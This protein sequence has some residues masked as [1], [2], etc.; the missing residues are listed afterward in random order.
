MKQLGILIGAVAL[1]LAIWW[2]TARDPER[3]RPRLVRPAEEE[4]NDPM[5]WTRAAHQLWRVAPGHFR[6]EEVVDFIREVHGALDDAQFLAVSAALLHAWLELGK[7]EAAQPH[8][9]AL[10][11]AIVPRILRIG[12]YREIENV[13][14]RASSGQQD[15]EA[16]AK[17]VD[18]V[19]T[20]LVKEPDRLVHGAVA[21]LRVGDRERFAR[22]LDAAGA[23][24]LVAP[25]NKAGDLTA[26][27]S[28]GSKDVAAAIE[29]W[30]DAA[31][32]EPMR[33]GLR[34]LLEQQALRTLRPGKDIPPKASVAALLSETAKIPGASEY[35]PRVARRTMEWMWMA[36]Y[37]EM[38]LHEELLRGVETTFGLMGFQTQL[39]EMAAERVV[40]VRPEDFSWPITFQERALL[41]AP[42]EAT[43]LRLAPD[44][45]KGLAR[46][47]EFD[48][49]RAALRAALAKANTER[50]RKKIE[51]LTEAL[52]HEEA[53]MLAKAERER[54]RVESERLQGQLKYMR[55]E[56]ERARKQGR[57]AEDISSIERVVRALER[58]STE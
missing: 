56:L 2:I 20:E 6:A 17:E 29:V 58:Q 22:L 36:H 7:D 9:A 50:G 24:E 42:D 37:A 25:L 41:S 39:W 18:A 53:K 10:A 38:K 33:H 28:Q 44:V 13:L 30:S 11:K 34:P 47:G 21:A 5:V 46:M 49:G 31:D 8:L 54:T 57:P 1:L 16:V 32:V 19:Y 12:T 27:P 43:A 15:A 26:R 52:T 4:R 55:E 35:W 45:M 40:G 23:S 3:A 51:D 14:A 48:R